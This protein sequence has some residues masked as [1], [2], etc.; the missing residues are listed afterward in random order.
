MSRVPGKE[1]DESRGKWQGETAG[2]WMAG[3]H[4]IKYWNSKAE[5]KIKNQEM[6]LG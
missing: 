5:N 2:G 1:R 6:I 3:F 4:D